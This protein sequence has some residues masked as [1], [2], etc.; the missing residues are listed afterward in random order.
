MRANG[1]IRI[2]A[3]L[4]D[5]A[6][7]AITTAETAAGAAADNNDLFLADRLDRRGRSRGRKGDRGCRGSAADL[8]TRLTDIAEQALDGDILALLC[9]DLE[10]H[11]VVLARD[12]VGEFICR[13]LKDSLA[14]LDSI[15]L[16]LEPAGYCAF[17]H[18]QSQLGHKN[19]VSHAIPS[20]T[21]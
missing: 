3:P 5:T 2:R 19:F 12:L 4:A 9:D 16:M 18:R 10:Q 7:G 21:D 17:F 13:D 15:P 20:L 11:A 6:A 14:S 1:E 8:F